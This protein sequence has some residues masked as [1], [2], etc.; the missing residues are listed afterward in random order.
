MV[1][2]NLDFDLDLI[3]RFCKVWG[4]KVDNYFIYV[5]KC[6]GKKKIYIGKI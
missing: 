4:V 5:E 1:V 2:L 6:V 3:F